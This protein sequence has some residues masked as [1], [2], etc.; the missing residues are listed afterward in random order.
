MPFIDTGKLHKLN[1]V[2]GDNKESKRN[3]DILT[4][5]GNRSKINEMLVK[6]T[7]II[8]IDRY[9]Y[10]VRNESMLCEQ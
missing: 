4:L 7:N 5:K 6:S 8:E 1:I 10:K 3:I 9:L 2:Y